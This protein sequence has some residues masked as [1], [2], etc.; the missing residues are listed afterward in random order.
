MTDR[1]RELVAEGFDFHLSTG[2][3]IPY[4]NVP[5]AMGVS[6]PE[7]ALTEVSGVRATDAAGKPHPAQATALGWWPDG[8]VKWALIELPADVPAA[9]PKA[10]A[11]Y[12]VRF[13]E[14]PGL[15]GDVTCAEDADGITARNGRLALRFDKRR[16]SL[17]REVLVDGKPIIREGDAGDIVIE[18]GAGKRYYA[19]MAADYRAEIEHAGSVRTTVRLSGKHTAPDGSAFLHFR[20]RV[21]IFHN[22]PDVLI[23]HQLANREDAMPGVKVSSLKIGQ[24]FNVGAAP[25]LALRQSHHGADT[26]PRDIGGV[27]QDVAIQAG[28]P[29]CQALGFQGPLVTDERIF[30]EDLSTMDFHIRDYPAVHYSTG[31]WLDISG[32][33]AGA[34]VFFRN[35]AENHPK[36]VESVGDRMLLHIVPRMESLLEYM[37]GW[38]KRHEIVFSF[39]AGETDP[40]ERDQTWYRWEHRPGVTVPF[41]WY[42]ST[43]A[44]DMDSIM[45]RQYRKYPLLE[46]KLAWVPSLTGSSGMIHW[47]DTFTGEGR[48]GA[49]GAGWNHEEDTPYGQFLLALRNGD[50][51]RFGIACIATRHMIDIDHIS[52]STDPLRD[53]AI[54]PHS[55]DHVRGATYPS[56]MW[57]TGVTL[58]YYL[59]GDPDA[60]AAAIAQGEV[61]LRFIEKRWR[62]TTL[63]GREHGWPILNLGFVYELTRDTKYLDGAKKLI[64]DVM[65]RLDEYGGVYYLHHRY[66]YG[67]FANYSIYEGMYKCWSAS[68]DPELRSWFLRVVDWLIDESFGER[69]FQYCRN[70]QWFANLYPLAMAYGMTG[71]EKYAQAGKVGTILMMTYHEIGAWCL[72]E[73]LHFLAIADQRGWIEACAPQNAELGARTSESTRVEA[74]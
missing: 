32:Q 10:E 27:R 17:F 30:G 24:R 28:T 19:S 6:L 64:A 55:R 67:E 39:H 34:T 26:E 11:S 46:A 59:T 58:Y 60:R 40:S 23:E 21:S 35:M 38:T 15:A 61:N 47:G 68:R 51:Y 52:Y 3:Y 36:I 72:R 4:S 42:Q 50:A 2:S 5:A 29:A 22:C 70:G 66:G 8:S 49:G 1:A 71:E 9:P 7:G 25:E 74:V 73:L 44:E 57:I 12:R 63:T 53:G 45:P 37:Q 48:W 65:R 14:Q 20:L 13:G 16:F 31:P 43:G 56:H 33:G 18:D 69:G 54:A 62:A 41:S